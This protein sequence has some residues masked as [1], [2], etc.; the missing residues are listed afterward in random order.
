M[1]RRVNA[2]CEVRSA[3]SG[4]R[5]AV[6]AWAWDWRR[7]RRRLRLQPVIKDGCSAGDRGLERYKG[8]KNILNS[9]LWPNIA[10]LSSV[11]TYLNFSLHLSHINCNSHT[12]WTQNL[13]SQNDKMLMTDLDLHNIL[14]FITLFSSLCISNCKRMHQCNLGRPNGFFCHTKQAAV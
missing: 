7:W 9:S 8:L 3:V 13:S 2:A 1:P 10:N 14:F 4:G 12:K 6:T 11:S 5:S